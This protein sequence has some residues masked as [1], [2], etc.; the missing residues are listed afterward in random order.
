MSELTGSSQSALISELLDG[1]TQV[2]DRVIKVLEAAEGAKESIRG[3]VRVDMEAAQGRVEAQFDLV[4]AEFDNATLPLLDE[5]EAIRRRSRR[6]ARRDA[7][8][9]ARRTTSATPTPLS[10]RG[11]RYDPTTT[12]SVAST[13]TPAGQKPK[14]QGVKVRG[15]EK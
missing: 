7:D 13:R 10:N 2:F 4:M 9:P 6:G 14:K 12:N 8:A 1:S 3:K 5:V 11:V 15:V